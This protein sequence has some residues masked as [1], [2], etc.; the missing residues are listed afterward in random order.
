MITS[1]TFRG[2]KW[3]TTFSTRIFD[4]SLKVFNQIL[5]GNTSWMHNFIPYPMST[6][7]AYFRLTLLH[8]KWEIHEKCNCND[9]FS[10]ISHFSCS[11]VHQKYETWVLLGWGI[12]FFIQWL[13][14]LKIW[15]KTLGDK[16]KIR[17]EKVVFS[18]F[19]SKIW[20]C[21]LILL[22]YFNYYFIIY[23]RN[24]F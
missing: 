20:W 4:L 17:V 9:I 2:K 15:V 5:S 14:P 19:P 12:K 3:K 16:L 23:L 6:H 1:S 18:F 8:E 13:L 11:R 21:N 24:P 10:C 22:Y 7:V